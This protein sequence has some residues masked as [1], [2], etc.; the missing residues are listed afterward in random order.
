[1]SARP[2]VRTVSEL[3]ATVAGWRKADETVALVPTMGALH[4][5]H[6]ALVR[7]ALELAD[8]AVASVFVNPTQ[9]A[10][11]EDFARYPRD[12]AGDAEKLAAAGCHLMYA[13]TVAEMYAE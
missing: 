4:E 9:F 6:L 5:G 1:M 10:P 8:R 13:P 12:E 2:I 3:R 11:H 7:R